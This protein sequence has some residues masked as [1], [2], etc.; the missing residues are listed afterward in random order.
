MQILE[1][2]LVKGLLTT[3]VLTHIVEEELLLEVTMQVLGL[4]MTQKMMY[5]MDHNLMV[6]GH[7]HLT[8]YGK[9][10]LT[11]MMVI[12]TFG[13]RMRIKEITPKVGNS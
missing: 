7:F 10:Y 1:V 13:M 12:I 8:G 2:R 6:A 9:H 5:F 11:Q 3:L 4:L